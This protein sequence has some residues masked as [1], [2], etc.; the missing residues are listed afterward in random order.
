[1]LTCNNLESKIRLEQFIDNFVELLK[2]GLIL[3][4]TGTGEQLLISFVYLDSHCTR[5]AYFF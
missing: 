5:A 1:M 4:F 2:T 3:A